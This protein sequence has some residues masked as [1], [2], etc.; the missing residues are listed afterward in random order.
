VEQAREEVRGK[1]R[2][3]AR[4]EEEREQAGK[5]KEM[6]KKEKKEEGEDESE[7]VIDGSGGEALVINS[8]FDGGRVGL[9]RAHHGHE[10]PPHGVVRVAG[11]PEQKLGPQRDLFVRRLVVLQE[12]V[13]VVHHG[14]LGRRLLMFRQLWADL[15]A[16]C[17]LRRA[18]GAP[19]DHS[20][21]TEP[22]GPL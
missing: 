8:G 7:K 2:E 4:E 18:L 20:M 9:Q 19:Q 21:G 17:L 5:E 10:E 6:K 14:T 16:L 13:E 1:E 15:L 11:T 3:Q 12:G 22:G